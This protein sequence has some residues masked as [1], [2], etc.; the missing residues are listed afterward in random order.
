M[1][2]EKHI[3]SEVQLGNGTLLA[4]FDPWAEIDQVFAPNI[5]ALQSRLGAFQTSVL[6]P[7]VGEHG[8]H[9]PQLLR[10]RPESFDIRLRLMPGSQVL[11]AEYQ[12]RT[13][14]LFLRRT[15]GLHPTEPVLLDRWKVVEGPP[16]GLLHESTPWMGNSTSAHCSLYHPSFNG[17][18]HHRGRRWLGIM[19][20]GETQWVRVGHLSDHDRYRLGNGERVEA[21][22]GANDLTGFPA[23]KVR[24]GWDQVVQGPAT[25][26]ALAVGPAESFEMV[27]I[28]AESERNLG[29]LLQLVTHI[30]T[31]RYFE[32]VES[33]V[34]SRLAPALPLLE[35]IEN[36]SVRALCERSIDVLHALQDAGTGALMA[37]AE[38][39]PHSSVS[40]GYG[41]SWPRDGAYLANALG[42]W[43]FR[44]RVD[45]YFRFL[46][47]TQDGSGAWWQ[48]YLATGHAGP[49]WGRIQID[50]PAT[51][52]VA[53]YNSYR[54]SGDLFW[55]EKLWPTLK[56]GLEFLEEF[57]SDEH[58]LGLP[59]HDL[60]E[61]R[62]GVHAYSLGAVGS[63]FLCGA[64]LARELSEPAVQKRYHA[65][66][67]R[68]YGLLEEHFLPKNG[69][70]R[71]AFIVTSDDYFRSGDIQQGG[72]YFDEAVDCSL[73]GLVNPFGMLG[74][75]DEVA[76]RIVRNVR[77]RLWSRPVGGVLRY[78]RDT[79]R[80]GNPWIL[81][82]LWLASVELEFGNIAEARECFQ[83]VMTK[84]TPLGM[85][86][87][88]IHRES[89]Q[90]FWVI[91]L[92]W[93]HAMYLLFVR[94]V[95]D[96]GMQKEIW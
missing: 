53:A 58:P 65:L 20:R 50:E 67:R 71:R 49:S 42:A 28:C 40:G 83:W 3:K 35:K 9:A 80:G 96:R 86:A 10:L 64:Y 2:W 60:W 68:L 24:Q 12:H 54:R 18:V 89:G 94:E 81:C 32:L 25:W 38:V 48:R 27:V 6:I 59:S 34:E 15:W 66:S 19:V 85:L 61:E 70:I 79:Y 78:E 47:E 17:L 91:P 87:E 36:A 7:G 76:R 1:G 92:G 4:T 69:P 39:D 31:P 43:N 93:S 84:T 11:Q 30:P 26:G 63:A 23:G 90:P 73:L 75:R 16:V 55:L 52:I 44:E 88:Q 22:I 21:P 5:D 37:A 62:M 56:K 13:L 95:L 72:G 46:V 33:R 51:V 14:R 41:Y 8:F 82:T 77:D 74:K 57:H 29:R 45:H